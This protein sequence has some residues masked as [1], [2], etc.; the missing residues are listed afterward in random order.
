MHPLP[1]PSFGA[2][3]GWHPRDPPGPPGGAGSP[4]L[5]R[6]RG[7]HTLTRSAG[8]TVGLIHDIPSCK[9]L[10]ATIERD[11]EQVI[12]GLQ[13]LTAPKAKL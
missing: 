9:E 7:K 13:K 11:A 12:H 3:S 8:E 4:R 6:G 5:G 10:C 2:A 1:F